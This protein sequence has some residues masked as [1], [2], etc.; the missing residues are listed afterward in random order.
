MKSKKNVLM[1]IILII[2]IFAMLY[3]SRGYLV[4]DEAPKQADVII[5]LSGD[6]GRL[7]K[8]AQLYNEGYADYVLLT[9]A[10][11]EFITKEEAINF[12]IPESQIILEEEATSTYTNA[13]YA[14]L[15][16][17]EH[18]FNS[19][20]VVSSD[21]HMRRTKLSFERVFK[22][23]DMELTYVAAPLHGEVGEISIQTAIKEYIKLVGYTLGMYRFI[24]LED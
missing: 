18:Q 3:I 21:Y 14:K 12:G 15:L 23:S 11:E 5:V 24:D 13:T 16:L 8:G 1:L 10:N 7:A 17:E 20:I 6:E 9:K 4:V 19:S 22:G 2:C